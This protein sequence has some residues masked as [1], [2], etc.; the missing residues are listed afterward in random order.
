LI[1]QQRTQSDFDRFLFDQDSSLLLSMLADH[2]LVV[3]SWQGVDETISEVYRFS[4]GGAGKG[5]QGGEALM[6]R[7]NFILADAN[8]VIVYGNPN[9]IGDQ[10]PASELEKGLSLVV[11]GKISGYL[12][13]LRKGAQE[14]SGTPEGDFLANIRQSIFISSL[15]AVGIALILGGILARTLTRP[16][17][18]LTKA[19]EQI[20]GGDL[21]YQV[22]VRSQDEMGQLATSFNHM[23]ADL[24]HANQLRRQMTADIA[25]D[26]RT[27][28]SLILGY[29][30]ALSDGKLDGTA[31]IYEVMHNESVHLSHLIDDLR[32]LSLADAGELT[33]NLQPISPVSLLER[34]SAAFR[35]QADAAGVALEVVADQGLPSLKVDPE[36]MA[37][38]YTNL[39]S[40]A[41][42]YTPSG[43]R[44]E[45]GAVRQVDLV[46]LTIR[47][48]G[49][50]ITPEDLPF[51]FDRFYRA[52]PARQATGE[53]GLGLTIARS[54][55]VAQGG[56]IQVESELGQ[57][58]LFTVAFPV[59]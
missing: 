11:E 33:L 15:L 20:A 49:S 1:I 35:A 24:A 25:H 10:V 7:V 54:L 27:P 6:R 21:G 40:N 59:K 47:D 13:G 58:T 51:V 9:R 34:T 18:E 55:V 39:V 48:T 43:G 42:R 45:L 8:G 29:T 4:Q 17:R 52:D 50:G 46:L 44:I 23:S 19:T 41:L 2:Y 36:R 14:H 37:Q 56:Q 53:A 3:G 16:I 30:E 38:V 28:L 26:L 12:L 32:T 5:Y 57:G 22:E 31:E